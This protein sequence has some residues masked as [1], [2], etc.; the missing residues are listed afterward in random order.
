MPLPKGAHPHPAGRAFV[1][2]H[3]ALEPL[4]RQG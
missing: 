2:T 3:L 4:A 1:L